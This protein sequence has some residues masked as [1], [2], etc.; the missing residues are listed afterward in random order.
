MNGLRLTEGFPVALFTE[1]TGLPITAAARALEKAESRGL[2]LR[3]H[4]CIRPTELGRRF[5]NDLL[6]MFLTGEGPE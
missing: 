1:R 5:L 3:D 4:Q 6:Q 2:V